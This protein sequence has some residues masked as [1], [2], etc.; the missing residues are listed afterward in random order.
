MATSKEIIL[1]G[2]LQMLIQRKYKIYALEVL[3]QSECSLDHECDSWRDSY[4]NAT[5]MTGGSNFNSYSSLMLK[6]TQKN[7]H[8]VTWFRE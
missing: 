4:D 2:S 1:F 6:N 3:V 7:D 5:N 8:C